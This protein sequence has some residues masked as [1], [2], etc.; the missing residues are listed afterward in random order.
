MKTQS[1][2]SDFKRLA[3]LGNEFGSWTA[4][5]AFAV[6]DSA[7]VGGLNESAGNEGLGF[8]RSR[9]KIRRL[10][11][12]LSEDRLGGTH[13]L[14]FDWERVER[15]MEAAAA[16]PNLAHVG[17][18]HWDARHATDAAHKSDK[19]DSASAH[20]THMNAVQLHNNAA[21]HLAKAGDH[22]TANVHK[23]WAKHHERHAEKHAMKAR[24]GAAKPAAAP[25]AKK[26]YEVHKDPFGSTKQKDADHAKTAHL[27]PPTKPTTQAD[28]DKAAAKKSAEDHHKPTRAQNLSYAAHSMGKDKSVSHK[29]IASTHDKAWKAHAGELVKHLRNGDHAKALTSLHAAIHSQK[30]RDHH[31]GAGMDQ[32]NQRKPSPAGPRATVGRTGGH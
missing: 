20:K 19:G 7:E 21:H 1:A 26:G 6:T 9:A 27:P 5:T 8:S 11:N 32:K 10:A 13:E 3:G 30:K 15:L 12:M 14:Q 24:G 18:A 22:A 4:S 2:V 28:R 31:H 17:K 29:D 25:A 23:Q 16:S